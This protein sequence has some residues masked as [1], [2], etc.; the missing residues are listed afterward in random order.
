VARLTIIDLSIRDVLS[1]QL[2]FAA[3]IL[4]LIILFYGYFLYESARRA[5]SS[6]FRRY[7]FR[8]IISVLNNSQDDDSIQQIELDFIKLSE[9]FPSEAEITRSSI[10]ILEDMVFYYDTL[11][12]KEISK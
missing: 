1:G 10:S 6:R 3:V 2:L 4:P 11:G 7:M 8:A 5:R 12:E 9:R